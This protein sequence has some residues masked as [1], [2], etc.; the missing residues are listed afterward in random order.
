MPTNLFVWKITSLKYPVVTMTFSHKLSWVRSMHLVIYVFINNYWILH[1]HFLIFL[2]IF[3]N[4]Q[5]LFK[6]IIFISCF[7]FSNFQYKLI[8]IIDFYY[9]NE[10]VWFIFQMNFII[11]GD[12]INNQRKVRYVKLFDFLLCGFPKIEYFRFY[13]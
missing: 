11:Y 4:S 7:N 9:N 8:S 6:E 3:I 12:D 5:H 10:I 2:D 13:S 1:S